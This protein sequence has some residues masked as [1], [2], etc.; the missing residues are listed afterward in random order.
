MRHTLSRPLIL[1]LGAWLLA[2]ATTRSAPA[3]PRPRL[4]ILTDFFRDPDDKQS[5]IRLLCYVNEFEIEG[6]LATSLA[7]GDGSVHPEWI[8]ALIEDEYAAVFPSLRRHGRPGFEFPEPA[9]L[10]TRVHGGAP[11]IRKW[12]GRGK[13]F[14]VPYPAGTRDSR[15]CDPAENWIGPGKDTAASDHI[16]RVADRDDPRP[17]WIGIWG[18]AM[19]LAQALWKVRHTRNA[20]EAAR[21][22]GKL[23]VYQVSWQDTGTV[24]IWNNVPELFLILGLGNYR[25]MIN[26][27]EPTGLGNKAWLETHVT[28]NHG[29]LGASYPEVNAYGRTE[30]TV[31]EG[32]SPSYFHLLAP[33]LNDPERPEWGGWGGRFERMSVDRP[34]FVDARDRHPASSDPQRGTNW[35][36][37]RWKQAIYADFAARMDWCVRPF[38]EANHPPVVHLDGDVSR[39]VLQRRVPAGQPATFTAAGSSDPDGHALS[40]RWW[41]Y[42]EPGTFSGELSLSSANSRELS[43]VAPSVPRSETIHLIL[44]VTDSGT[45]P[46]TTY[47]RVV[48][49]VVPQP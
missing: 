32:D 23:R 21:F 42:R 26:D 44:E 20:A 22:I 34:R 24:W 30:L 7:H 35:T 17:V 16:I 1:F 5:M 9:Q 6:L 14:A 38:A 43:V 48:V 39:R 36:V 11:V 40:Y 46:L 8:K 31:K 47:R 45:P 15:T 3:D 33:G 10:A 28:H 49:T 13:G 25:G 2:G 12:A 41:H 29:K 27:E 4:I 19:D 18:G 37:G